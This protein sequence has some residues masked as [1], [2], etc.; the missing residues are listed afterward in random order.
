[1]VYCEVPNCGAAYFRKFAGISEM[2]D[3]PRHI[4][5][6]TQ[7]SLARLCAASGLK[8]IDW[9][10][11]G[12]TRHFGRPWREWENRIHD[13]L[14]E[15]GSPAAAPRRTWVTDYALLARSAFARP[16]R[17]YDCIGFF[18]RKAG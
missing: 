6:F 11:H 18:A 9:H 13:M 5:V 12:Y 17:K 3:V 8:V 2:L 14:R 7:L 10:F 1:V 16:E 15:H 4:H